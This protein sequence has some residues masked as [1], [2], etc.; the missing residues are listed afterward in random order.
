VVIGALTDAVAFVRRQVARAHEDIEYPWWIIAGSVTAMLGGTVAAVAQR[1]LLIPPGLIALTVLAPLFPMASELL[2]ARMCSPLLSMAVTCAAVAWLLRTP[3]QY[4]FAPL[5]L[6]LA[7]GE[8]SATA[9]V[10]VSLLGTAMGVATL[11]TGHVHGGIM[12]LY[13]VTQLAAWEIG[14]AM[15][16]QLRLLQ[17]ERRRHVAQEAEAA[18]TERQRIAREIHDVVAHSLSVTMLHVTGARRMLQTDRDVDEAVGAL[19]DAERVGRQALAEIRRTVGLL[20]TSGSGTAVLPGVGDIAT[21]VDTVRAAGVGVSYSL[22]G[23]P[24]GVGPAA[25]LGL[26]RIAQ[27]SL[28]NVT[29]HAPGYGATVCLE[30][31]PQSARLEIR[32]ETSALAP[33]NGRSGSG[34]RGMQDRAAQLG[35]TLSAGPDD[36]GWRVDALIPL[37]EPE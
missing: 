36:A 31:T 23:D 37:E 25:G 15:Q 27:E 33:P 13:L 20:G 35:G 3:T 7:T 14:F 26:Y 8:L 19:Q 1:D 4:D 28:A 17:A 22:A 10:K 16:W 30:V 29:K 21:L 24:T 34:V 9:S 18:T 5:V 11:A 2:F 6:A 12:W 32:N